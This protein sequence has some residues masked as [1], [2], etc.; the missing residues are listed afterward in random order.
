MLFIDGDHH[1]RA[2]IADFEKYFSLVN[3]GGYIVFDDYLPYEWK[4]AKRECPVAI[5]D[6]VDKYKNHIEVIGLIEDLVG[7]NKLRNSSETK[8]CDF[9][10]QKK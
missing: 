7:C 1:R 2:V 5:N 4:G 9:I 8:N 6:L 3:S 10:V